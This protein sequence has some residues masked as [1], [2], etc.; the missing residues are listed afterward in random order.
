MSL[1]KEGPRTLPACVQPVGWRQRAGDGGRGGDAQPWGTPHHTWPSRPSTSLAAVDS[2]TLCRGKLDC[3]LRHNRSHN[4]PSAACTE[5]LGEGAGLRNDGCCSQPSTSWALPGL[6][7]CSGWAEH[8]PHLCTPKE[9]AWHRRR[10]GVSLHW[11]MS[12]RVSTS[13]PG[14][15]LWRRLTAW[16][17]ASH[18]AA[19]LHFLTLLNARDN[20]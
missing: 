10:W 8:F 13:G 17:K 18:L 16:P 3:S 11:G 19:F 2:A 15:H 20:K 12:H 5:L 1:L 14:S 4:S 7:W 9:L 6:C